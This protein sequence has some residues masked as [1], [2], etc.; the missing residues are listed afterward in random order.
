MKELYGNE[1]PR[2]LRML[3][4]WRQNHDSIDFKW[5]YFA[6]RFGFELVL[7]RGGYFDSHYAIAFN[8]GWGHFHIKL[9]F[10]T[11]LAEGCDLPRYGFQFYEDLFWIH[12]GG[13]FDASIGQVTSG[14]TWT[15]YLLFKHWIFEG[16]WIANKEGRWYKVEKGQN[17]WEVREQI[18]HT[19]VHDY[20]YTLKSGEVQK[21]KATCT[22]EK[23]K[24]HRKW[25]PFLKM[26]RVNID[27]QFD[28]E[29]GERAWDWKGGTVGCSYVKL[30]H[31]SIEQCLRRMEK[32]REFN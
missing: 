12:K 24:W 31:E 14:G 30:P 10:R 29:V 2:W 8:L 16:H 25:F 22:L 3:G 17:S 4:A 1:I 21:R 7:H 32:E 23:R 11:S 13:N 18:G 15:W 19:E 26:E 20:A 9:P 6:P 28:G 5:G 27:V